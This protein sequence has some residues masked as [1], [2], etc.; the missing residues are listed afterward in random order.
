LT[1]LNNVLGDDAYAPAS[2]NFSYMGPGG[3]PRFRHHQQFL[4]DQH[5]LEDEEPE[6]HDYRQYLYP[7]EELHHL[8]KKSL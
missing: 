8:S 1:S 6:H 7:P 4:S 3:D 5:Q 2:D